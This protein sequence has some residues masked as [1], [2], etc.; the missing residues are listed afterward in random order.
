MKLLHFRYYT[1]GDTNFE[2]M[3][4]HFFGIL[5]QKMFSVLNS[6]YSFDDK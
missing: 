2:L 4:D 6:Q 3:M 5:Y 1:L